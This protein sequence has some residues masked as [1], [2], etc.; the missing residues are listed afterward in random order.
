MVDPVEAA[1]EQMEAAH[2][3]H[4]E[5][6]GE[7]DHWGRLMAVAVSCLAASLA[8]VDLG[9][10]S[11]QTAYLTHNISASDTW[12]AYQGKNLR[13]SVWT[14]QATMLESLPNAADPA[15]QERIKTAHA[16]ALR[17]RDEPAAGDGM[18]Q[19]KA[20]AEDQEHDR[21]LAFHAYHGF[22]YT[23]SALEIS[24]VLASVSVV[25]RVHVLG[26]VAA[27]IGVLAAGYGFMVFTH[28]V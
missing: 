20:K 21:E 12:N 5:A 23:A 2:E 16:E 7:S 3:R 14:T 13:A 4:A 8:L 9:A 27:G 25:T 26:L 18:K 22:E 11:S 6:H 15:I 17:M 24:I 10:K 28:F 19:L 1:K